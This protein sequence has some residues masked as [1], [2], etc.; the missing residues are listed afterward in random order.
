MYR[1]KLSTRVSFVYYVIASGIRL[2]CRYFW[3]FYCVHLIKGKSGT[4]MRTMEALWKL[5]FYRCFDHIRK[6]IWRILFTFGLTLF[7]PDKLRP[8]QKA[9]RLPLLTFQPVTHRLNSRATVSYVLYRKILLH[10][11]SFQLFLAGLF[12]H[13][14]LSL[15]G[16]PLRVALLHC[17]E[18]RKDVALPLFV[19]VWS[20]VPLHLPRRPPPGGGAACPS[21]PGFQTPAGPYT[22]VYFHSRPWLNDRVQE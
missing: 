13:P 21:L 3:N 4:W 18:L 14:T 19:S 10:L 9:A 17:I 11:F 20:L 16:P 1:L 7:V 12:C 5:F 8:L 15:F 2:D 22:K 6:G